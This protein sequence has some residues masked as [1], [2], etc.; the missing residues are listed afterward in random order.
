MGFLFGNDNHT[1]FSYVE[2]QAFMVALA[3]IIVV[4]LLAIEFTMN[5][6]QVLPLLFPGMFSVRER[7][8]YFFDFDVSN[9]AMAGRLR[10]HAKTLVRM[11]LCMVLSYLWQHCV[12]DTTQR[13]GTE[14][15]QSQCSE[16]ADCWTSELHFIT[17]LRRQHTPVDCKA[18]PVDYPS[19]V[20]VSCIRFIDPSASSWL[21]HFAIAHSVTQL[22][23]KSFELLV[24][25]AGNSPNTRRMCGVLTFVS[26]SVCIGLFFGGVISEFASSWLSFVTTLS[27]PVFFHNVHQSAKLLEVLYSEESARV[28]VS[29]EQH[30]NQALSDFEPEHTGLE[31]EEYDRHGSQCSPGHRGQ[32]GTTMTARAKHLLKLS[33]PSMLNRSKT[34]VDNSRAGDTDNSDNGAGR[35]EVGLSDLELNPPEPQE[36]E[37]DSH[38]L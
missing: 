21:M 33:L 29:I 32:F 19:R 1:Q 2:Y 37:C 12:M 20:V 26:L 23:L 28:H 35:P 31:D 22:N 15:P 3:A 10:S 25:V 4:G 24:W 6:F 34:S 38:R 11:T 13:V 16:M 9:G 14:F 36:D 30:F 18:P 27:V 7:R 5:R 8:F 17:L